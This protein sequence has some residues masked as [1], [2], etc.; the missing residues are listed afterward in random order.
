MVET[1]DRRQEN[2]NIMMGW[3]ISGQKMAVEGISLI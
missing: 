1:E 2:M 3:E